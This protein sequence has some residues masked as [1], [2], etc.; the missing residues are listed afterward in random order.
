MLSY[1]NV[2]GRGWPGKLKK[3]CVEPI[4]HSELEWIR[5]RRLA[6]TWQTYGLETRQ[7]KNQ[8][9][10]VTDDDIFLPFYYYV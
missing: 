1:E 7:E 6:G 8:S 5:Q 9:Y 2:L 4:F 3:Y 10:K